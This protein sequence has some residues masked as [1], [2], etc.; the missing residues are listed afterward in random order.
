[1]RIEKNEIV[2]MNILAEMIYFI[3]IGG[4]DY[5][6]DFLPPTKRKVNVPQQFWGKHMAEESTCQGYFFLK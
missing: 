5:T 1:M 4:N 2:N 3:L 6:E